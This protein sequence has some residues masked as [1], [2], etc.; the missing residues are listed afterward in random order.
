[1]DSGVTAK[2]IRR[3]NVL[4][5]PVDCVDMS[6]ALDYVDAAVAGDRPCAI[7]AVNPE[8]VMRAREDEV[9]RRLLWSAGLL[10]PD[11]IGVVLAARL[12]GGGPISRVP[13]AELMP[14]I[15]RLAAERGYSVFLYGAA[16]RV[17]SAAAAALTRAYPDLRI[18]GRQHG[19]LSNTEMPQVVAAINECRPDVLF[20][21]LGSPRQEIWLARHLPQLQVK[22]CQGVGGTFDV[23]A[24]NVSRAPAFFRRAGLEWFYR[25][26]RQPSR[27]SRQTALPR[28]V[29]LLAK[30]KVCGDA[31]IDVD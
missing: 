31:E 25:L 21:A 30:R 18:V 6:R 23:L 8:K 19:Y 28:F 24:G 1:M 22:V 29:W 16:E 12:L 14:A 2:S 15:C 11:G 26:L 7:V 17:N 20:V 13:G 5:A 10:I 27:A 4:G 3:M 9:L